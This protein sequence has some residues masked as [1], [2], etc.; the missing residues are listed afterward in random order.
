MYIYI[1]IYIYTYIYIH[2]YISIYIYTTGDFPYTML[3]H[4]RVPPSRPANQTVFGESWTT[5]CAD[6]V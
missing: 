2:T 3:T 6:I 4:H 5:R 1:Y